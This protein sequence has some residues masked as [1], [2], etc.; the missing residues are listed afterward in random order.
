MK[1]KE[2]Q[3]GLVLPP[4]PFKKRLHPKIILEIDKFNKLNFLET[5]K[6]LLK[7]GFTQK[8]F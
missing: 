4:N 3:M 5:K 7:K 8:L 2:D 6:T 1:P